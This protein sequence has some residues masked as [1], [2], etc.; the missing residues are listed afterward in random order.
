MQHY[1]AC[2]PSGCER[3]LFACRG[4]TSVVVKG[5]CALVDQHRSNVLV[6]DVRLPNLDGVGV[7]RRLRD[8]GTTTAIL[9][10]TV[11]AGRQTVLG[12]LESGAAGFVLKDETPGTLVRA[13]RAAARGES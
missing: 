5:P 8:R 7:T 1:K 10:L 9:I 3:A 13:V 6:L 11:H 12:L 4:R 2:A